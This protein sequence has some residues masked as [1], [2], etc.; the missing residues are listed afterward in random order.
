MVDMYEWMKIAHPKMAY[1]ISAI[2]HA[3]VDENEKARFNQ[4]SLFSIE[5]AKKYLGYSPRPFEEGMKSTASWLNYYEYVP[6]P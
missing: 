6:K 3:T 1:N 2:L 5:K 4:R